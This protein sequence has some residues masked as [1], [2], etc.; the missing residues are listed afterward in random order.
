MTLTTWPS[1]SMV[2]CISQ[3]LVTPDEPAFDLK[4][5]LPRILLPVVVQILMYS[6]AHESIVV[7]INGDEC[8]SHEY[9]DFNYMQN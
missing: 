2:L 3:V 5:L 8:R 4:A 7:Q 6:Q 1:L 9:V